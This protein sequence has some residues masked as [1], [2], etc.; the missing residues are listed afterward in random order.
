MPSFGRMSTRAFTEA[1]SAR[2]RS[3]QADSGSPEMRS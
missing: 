2:L 3:S 1:G